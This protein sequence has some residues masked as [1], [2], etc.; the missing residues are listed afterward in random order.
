MT[1]EARSA[2]GSS[3][4]DEWAGLRAS[5]RERDQVVEIRQVAAGDGRLTAAGLDERLDGALRA[6]T[7]DE[8]ARLTVDLPS[9]GMPPQARDL[10]RIDQRFGDV[11][12]TRR[13]PVPRRMEIRLMFCEAKFDFTEA[14]I[15]H[16]A[17]HIDVDL[18]VGET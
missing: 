5:D 18:R 8:L 7:R 11:S 10:V 12:R 2:D 1:G 13:W 4:R 9:E 3:E 17:L 14:V 15:T 6:R 16:G